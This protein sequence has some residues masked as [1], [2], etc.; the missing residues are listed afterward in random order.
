[1]RHHRIRTRARD[2]RVLARLGRLA[3]LGPFVDLA[4][5]IGIEHPRRPALRLGGVAGLIPNLRVDPAGHGTA[6]G[7]PKRVVGVIAELRVVR[8]EASVDE[9]V[10]HRLGIEHRDLT[11]GAVEREY[12]GRGMVRILLAEGWVLDSAHGRGEPHPAGLVEHAVVVV[13]ALTPDLLVSPIGRGL[14]RLRCGG[15]MER[16]PERFRR[17]RIRDRHFEERR[18]VRLRVEDRHVVA[19]VLGRPVERTIRVDGGIAPVR[20]DQIMDKG[21]LTAPFPGG[22]DEI[23]LHALRALRLVLGQLALGDAIDPVAVI[24]ARHAAE[25]SGTAV[26][27]ELAG[28]PGGNAAHPCI[29]T[30]LELAKLRRDSAGRFLTELMA[31]D[32]IDIAHAL[33]PDVARDVLRDVSG[34]AEILFRRHLQ[35]RVPVDRR[36]IM[37]RR[38]LIRRRHGGE[39]ELLAGLGAHLGRIHEPIAAHPDAVVCPRQ[40]G[41]DVA[42][43]VVGDDHLGVFGR[44]VG[45]LGDHPD[46]GLRASRPSHHAANV[47]IVDGNRRRLLGACGHHCRKRRKAD[48]RDGGIQNLSEIHPRLP[49]LRA[50]TARCRTDL[51]TNRMGQK[52]EVD[53]GN[54]A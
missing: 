20:G 17:I 50:L 40:I 15:G 36:I 22:D 28:L 4:V 47:I 5:A 46:A 29:L 9:A 24:L 19:R 7:E 31:A 12:L 54:T 18:L 27:H 33:T 53:T 39:I 30:R 26:H 51:T 44:K 2:A 38:P 16:R 42:A 14:V 35:K 52:T 25:L 1:M 10:L 41:N 11:S 37:R 8:A 49:A 6:A 48:R 23:A 32:A 13:G 34:A 43:L 3:R 45:G 21:L